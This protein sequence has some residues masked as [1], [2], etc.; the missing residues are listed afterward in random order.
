MP[1]ATP[2]TALG[3]GNG[4]PYCLSKVDVS[5]SDYWTTLGGTQKGETATESQKN[6]SIVNAMKIVWNF[7]SIDFT[8]SSNTSDGSKSIS[9]LDDSGKEPKERLCDVGISDRKTER[10]SGNTLVANYDDIPAF[11][12]SRFYDGSTSDENNYVGVG[13]APSLDASS[14]PPLFDISGSA[15]SARIAYR[16]SGVGVEPNQLLTGGT[17]VTR[18]TGYVTISGL[19]FVY[20]VAARG[21]SS[22]SRSVSS[23]A[24]SASGSSYAANFSGPSFTFYTFPST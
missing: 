18:E 4:F 9:S 17:Y 6:L 12:F 16:L 20:E 10:G 22:D 21:S 19:P 13:M 1:T 23:T 15:S 8:L 24:C 11:T 14:S 2:F 5:G 7:E 3:A